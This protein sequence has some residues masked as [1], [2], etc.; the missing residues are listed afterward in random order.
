MLLPALICILPF[1]FAV[2]ATFRFSLSADSQTISGWGLDG[3][4][5]LLD[6]YFYRTYYTTLKLALI[7]TI[8]CLI[9]AVPIALLMVSIQRSWLRRVITCVILL[10]MIVNLLI[11]S[12]GW[13]IVLGNNGV[14]NTTLQSLNLIDEPIQLLFNQTGVLVGLV[15]TALPLTVFPILVSMRAVDLSYLEAAMSL[16]ASPFRVFWS[17]I[18]PLLK[19]GLLSAG[20]IAFAF[21]ASAFAVPLLL[22]G[23]KV[24]MVG[25]AIRDM[26]TPLFDWSSAAAAGTVLIVITVAIIAIAAWFA[27]RTSHQSV[28][29]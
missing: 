16:G 24:S 22:G 7:S 19:P 12:Y 28:H 6:P 13:I 18:L 1:A 2:L 15:Q 21:N 8:I 17:I 27:N 26:I 3:Y 14:I 29:G 10:P 11:Q 25:T 5:E 4:R 9:L 23:R 20:S